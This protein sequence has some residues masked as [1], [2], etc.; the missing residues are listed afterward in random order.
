MEFPVRLILQP[1]P[2][3]L[4]PDHWYFQQPMRLFIELVLIALLVM[5]NR[6]F[7][8]RLLAVARKHVGLMLGAMAG[9]LLIFALLELEQL[10]A[11]LQQPVLN[12]TLW[13]LTGMC[14]GVGQ[15]LLYRGMLYSALSKII[16]AG[17]ARVITT[18]I[19]VIAP[20]HSVRLWQCALQDEWIIIGI[21]I[22]TYCVASIF[23]QW[24][25]DETDSVMA[26]ALA[27]GVGNAITW[28][29]VFA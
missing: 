5:I 23:F 9:S 19:F 17:T 2:W 16:R 24:L 12:W 25:R 10:Q 15:E 28:V 21:L 22:M 20:L 3:L 26:P 14:I 13:L 7:Y 27:H 4:S 8:P 18:L 1:D 29:A 6:R 11:S